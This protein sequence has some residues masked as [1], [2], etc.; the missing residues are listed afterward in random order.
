MQD[1]FADI[2]AESELWATVIS[3]ADQAIE[4]EETQ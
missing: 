3:D 4:Q 2:L 1:Y